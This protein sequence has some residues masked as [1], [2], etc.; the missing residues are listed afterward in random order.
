MSQDNP[1]PKLV[2]RHLI[3]V[4]HRFQ[5]AGIHLWPTVPHCLP[6]DCLDHLKR[7]G[8]NRF[9]TDKVPDQLPLDQS[10]KLPILLMMPI[11][12][13]LKSLQ[14]S[15]YNKEAEVTTTVDHFA[16][17]EI[18]QKA[19]AEQQTVVKVL[20]AINSGANFFGCR[21]GTDTLQLAKATLKQPNLSFVGL[22]S[23]VPADRTVSDISLEDSAIS[24][25]L[26]TSFKIQN[27]GIDCPF[28]HLRTHALVSP[29]RIP[30]DWHVSI[31]LKD[32]SPT[33]SELSANQP[34]ASESVSATVIARPSLQAAVIDCGVPILRQASE[35]V[36]TTGDSLPIKQVDDSRCVLDMTDATTELAIGQQ[37]H[38]SPGH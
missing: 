32:I 28:M 14:V 24:A 3:E 11:A 19:A 12:D 10:A 33:E 22:T 31:P 37:I 4:E 16:Q 38:F 25:M 36:L 7:H 9:A 20:V 23:E 26:E 13:P 8:I 2:D 15:V 6:N 29:S 21:P 35:I 1:T 34:L 30:T 27:K 17:I 5:L 18:L